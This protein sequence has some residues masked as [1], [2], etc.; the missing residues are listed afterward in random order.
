MDDL[1]ALY[2]VGVNCLFQSYVEQILAMIST[3][4]YLDKAVEG[5]GLGEWGGIQNEYEKRCKT[6]FA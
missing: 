3:R 2:T 4:K 1:G 6:T 5:N